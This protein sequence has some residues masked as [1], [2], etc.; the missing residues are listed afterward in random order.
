MK[1]LDWLTT[2]HSNGVEL[3]IAELLYYQSKLPAFAN[4]RK[5][6]PRT[7]QA[8]TSLSKIRGRGM[9]FDEVRQ[10]Q[11]GDDIR[12]IDWRVTARTGQPHTKLYREEKERPVF[13]LT[14]FSPSQYFG[15]QLLFKSVQSAHLAAALAWLAQKRGDRVGGIVANVQSH[16]ELKPMARQR[17]VL[18]Y[19]HSLVD[20][21]QQGLADWRQGQSGNHSQVLTEILQRVDRLARP[22]SQLL[23]I[24]D[25]YDLNE[26]TAERLRVLAKHYPI[27]AFWIIDPFE[28]ELPHAVG[29][30]PLAVTDGKRQ[31]RIIAGDKQQ[32]QRYKNYAAQRQQHVIQQLNQ[33]GIPLHQVNSGLALEQQWREVSR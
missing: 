24:S 32:Q 8:G 15:S 33:A 31:R 12:A 26:N 4:K 9:E 23:L 5:K 21:H 6:I 16:R 13:V 17:G 25:F 7:V 18:H 29:L 19:L 20:L 22:G 10:Y 28:F 30:D 2:L 11:P 27:E 14:D 1:A 3:G